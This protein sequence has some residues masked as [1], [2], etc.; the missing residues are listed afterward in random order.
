[1]NYLSFS[2]YFNLHFDIGMQIENMIV[3]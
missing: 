2:S 1:M 3:L